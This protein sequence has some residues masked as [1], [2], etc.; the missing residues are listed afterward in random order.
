MPIQS[1]QELLSYELQTIF[2]AEEQA[3]QALQ[4][5][6]QSAD[7]RQIKGM[8]DRRLKQGKQVLQDVQKGL[9]RLDGSS[10]RS[11]QNAAARGL[12]QE[13]E[14]LAKEVRTPEMKQ[15]VTID[16]LQKLEHYCIAA[17]G[18]AKAMARECGEQ[19]LA[20]SMERAIKEGY[21]WD[22]EM[23]QLAEGRINPEALGQSAQGR[24]SRESQGK[25]SQS[26]SSQSRSGQTRRT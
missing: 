10:T 25:Q 3:A 12:I 1:P 24:S 16:G 13:C 2:D 14:R 19:D 17:W 18:T 6:E 20:Q 21:Q 9:N 15:A 8:I 11:A 5:F 22:K 7:D 23:T 4:Q 26:K